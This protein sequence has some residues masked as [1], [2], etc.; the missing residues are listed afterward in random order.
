MKE[1]QEIKTAWR[2]LSITLKPPHKLDPPAR[3]KSF[4][5][6]YERTNTSG[7]TTVL[8]T[9]IFAKDEIGVVATFED[10]M[11]RRKTLRS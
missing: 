10:E 7:G 8:R 6:V 1:Q 2:I 11:R 4:I 9:L 3:G 5:V